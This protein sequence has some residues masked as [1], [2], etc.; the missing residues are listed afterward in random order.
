MK[1]KLLV[2]GVS[3][4]LGRSFQNFLSREKSS[5]VFGVDIK[6]EPSDERNFRCDLCSQKEITDVLLN[7]RPDII[8]HF[9]GGRA[10]NEEVLLKTIFLTT[11]ILF[12]AILSIEGFK[13]RVVIPGSSAEYGTLSRA[14]KKIDERADTK[15]SSW[16][17]FVKL[18]QTNVALFYADQGVDV[19]IG[20][21]FNILGEGVP[22][23][24]CVGRFAEQI[25]SIE[26]GEE[27]RTINTLSLNSVRDF[28]DIEDVCRA[29]LAIAKNGKSGE[30]YNICSG[31]GLSIK[32]LLARLI[33]YSGVTDILINEKAGHSESIFKSIGSTTKIKRTVMWQ[34][35]IN[36][37][38]SL[39]DTLEYYRHS[40]TLCYE[41]SN[42][43]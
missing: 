35:K 2:T 27:E 38:K 17:G 25:V 24:L 40:R 36:I 15:P 5:E 9:A 26:R 11:K 42:R 21:I 41:N 30:I 37:E 18:M 22:S 3:G 19:V 16:Y 28:L 32:D 14:E 12:N 39:K 4:F 31:S 7:V 23:D 6:C 34:P 1:K 8:Y 20:R 33:Q 29:L 10:R 13:P 43:T